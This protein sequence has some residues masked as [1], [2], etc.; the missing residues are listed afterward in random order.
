MPE[1]NPFRT[2]I[3]RATSCNSGQFHF[4]MGHCQ[5]K[6]PLAPAEGLRDRVE[7]HQCPLWVMFGRGT[8]NVVMGW[9][10]PLDERLNDFILAL[11]CRRWGRPLHHH[12][13]VRNLGVSGFA[14]WRLSL[15]D[16]SR[17]SALERPDFELS[18]RNLAQPYPEGIHPQTACHDVPALPAWQ[19]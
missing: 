6:R 16:A 7:L 9:T 19:V 5:S 2:A 18:R 4:G 8:K 11:R 14:R 10:A 13:P 3:A 12:I 1:P 17:C 15:F